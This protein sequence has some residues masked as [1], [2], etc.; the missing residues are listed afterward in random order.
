MKLFCAGVGQEFPDIPNASRRIKPS[1]VELCAT[2]GVTDIVE[3][4]IGFDGIILANSTASPQFNLTLHDI[5]LALAK[6]VPD[7]QGTRDAFSE[8]AMEGGCKTFDLIKAL[9]AS[10][11]PAYK[12][13][14]HTIREDGTYIEAGEND[15]L[16]AQKLRANVK[17]G[18]QKSTGF[19]CCNCNDQGSGS[20]S[21]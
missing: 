14:C 11:K 3:A 17:A 12:A 5:F 7:G 1:E 10:D 19:P 8:L 18:P 16:I 9:K 21:I 13:L 4:M 20:A 15:N 6:D 2:N